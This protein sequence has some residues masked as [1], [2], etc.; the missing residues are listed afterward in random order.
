MPPGKRSET[1]KIVGSQ[2]CG[3]E[4]GVAILGTKR[5]ANTAVLRQAIEK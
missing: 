5:V 3:G 4:S 1:T 2:V